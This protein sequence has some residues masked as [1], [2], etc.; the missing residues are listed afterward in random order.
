MAGPSQTDRELA[1]EIRVLSR[2]LADFRV[3]VSDRLGAIT[4][5]LEA[6][7]VRSETSIA[8]ARWAVNLGVV[9]AISLIGFA[10]TVTWNASKLDS[11]VKQQGEQLVELRKSTAAQLDRVAEQ[12]ARLEQSLVGRDS[13]LQRTLAARDGEIIAALKA[14]QG[15]V[16]GKLP[17]GSTH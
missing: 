4:A 16:G 5:S 10:L 11:A 17:S 6:I 13:A 15:A 9:V 12:N 2:Q 3:D 1:E 7:R 14:I 8:I